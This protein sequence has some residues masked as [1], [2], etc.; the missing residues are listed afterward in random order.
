MPAPPAIDDLSDAIAADDLPAII[1]GDELIKR[2]YHFPATCRGAC[3]DNMRAY[4]HDCRIGTGRRPGDSG[5][6]AAD[7]AQ[8]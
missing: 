2:H 8:R 7:I 3:A 5:M 1:A 6:P 4:Q